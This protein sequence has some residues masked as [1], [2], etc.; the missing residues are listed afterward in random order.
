MSTTAVHP[1]CAKCGRP[2][3][4][5][6]MIYSSSRAIYHPECAPSFAASPAPALA[7]SSVPEGWRVVPIEPTE[8]MHNAAR[9]WS[10]KKYGIP[11]GT[12]ASA[13]C[14]A[15]MI[16]ASP[17]PVEAEGWRDIRSAPKD[18]TW[19]LAWCHPAVAPAVLHWVGGEWSDTDDPMP[20]TGLW[21]PTHWKPSPAGPLPTPPASPEGTNR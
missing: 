3:D 17:A 8:A 15:A 9:D 2:V 20:P 18:G 21:T 14:W 11:I 10:R 12:D 13:G 7:P 6:G 19:I 4:G 1:N 5:V 16:S